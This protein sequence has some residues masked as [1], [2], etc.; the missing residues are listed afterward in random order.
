MVAAG[1][2]GPGRLAALLDPI[3]VDEFFARYRDREHV[4]VHRGEP[5]RYADLV[6]LAGVESYIFETNPR[7]SD[8]QVLHEGPVDRA[9]YVY[10]SGLVDALALSRLYEE[11]HSIVLPHAHLHLASL[12]YLVRGLEAELG[13]RAQ[14]NLY[15]SPPG[16]AAFAP[17]YD[18]H[19]VLVLQAHGEK[20]WT[21]YE[22]PAPVPSTRRFDP[23]VDDCGDPVETF[24]LAAGDVCYVPRGLV[25]R[26]AATTG[27]SLHVTL[28]VHWVTVLDVLTA[29]LEGAGAERH[30][31]HRSLPPGWWRDPADRDAA[32]TAVADALA[33]LAATPLL[34]GAFDALRTDLVRTRQPLVPGQLDQLR[35][36]DLI[37]QHT[38]VAPRDPMVHDLRE[39][40]GRVVLS[41]FGSEIAFPSSTLP[42]LA[43][44]LGA[45]PDGVVVGDLPGDLDGEERLVLVRRLV[46]EG[47]LV[48]RW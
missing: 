5:K 9:E 43:R 31:L 37:D 42:A 18:T 13:C 20:E 4:V 26:A 24:T 36:L 16:A 19:D 27:A 33:G 12:G 47:T 32:R 6:D 48:A 38:R 14:T 29:V 23:E 2:A 35:H 25:H 21:L 41:C 17:H 40:D 39:E 46:R 7:S 15:L 28:G 44:L 45:G 8:L 30:D 10:P 11:G 1:A 3:G 22:G 34:D